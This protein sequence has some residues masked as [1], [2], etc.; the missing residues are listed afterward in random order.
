[1]HFISDDHLFGI[2]TN[3]DGRCYEKE[4]PDAFITLYMG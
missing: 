3:F 2:V 1:M 4:E